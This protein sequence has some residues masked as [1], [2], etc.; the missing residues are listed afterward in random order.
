[1]SGDS[2]PRE[3]LDGEELRLGFHRLIQSL[4]FVADVIAHHSAYAI[5]PGSASVSKR[6]ATVT[7]SPKM[8]CSST[9]TSPRFTPIRRRSIEGS[10]LTVLRAIEGQAPHRQALCFASS[11]MV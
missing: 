11:S 5:P 2:P 3:D 10:K 7:P 8:S 4:S 1:M 6:A 9:I